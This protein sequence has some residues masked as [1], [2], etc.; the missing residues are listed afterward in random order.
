M[1]KKGF[2]ERENKTPKRSVNGRKWKKREELRENI[3][4]KY[5]ILT[6]SLHQIKRYKKYVLQL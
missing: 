1:R 2:R 6:K 5:Q 3:I 4:E